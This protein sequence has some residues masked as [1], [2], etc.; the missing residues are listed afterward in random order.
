MENNV[1]E[2]V[3]SNL[4]WKLAERYG[5]QIVQFVVS[6]VLAR[7]LMPEIYGTIAL[8]MVFITILQVFV[9]SGFGS[10]LIQKKDSDDLDFSTVFY[11]NIIFCLILYVLIFFL[12]PVIASFYEN[13]DLTIIIRVLSISLIFSSL[14]NVQ[15]SYVSKN[16]MFKKF[17][18]A[19][20]IGTVCSAF[21]GIF[22]ALKGFGIWAIVSQNLTN[23][24]IDTLVL[25]ITV[26]WRPKKYFSFQRLK[27]LFSYGWKLLVSALL[28][29]SYNE[30][31]Q[32][33]IGKKYSK[34]DLAYYNKGEQFPK[35]IIT[36]INTS[37][38]S[39]LFSAMSSVQD[40]KDQVRMLTKKSIKLS[41]YVIAPMM[42]GLAVT[43]K[44][45]I[46]LVLTEKWLFATFFMQIFCITYM[47]Y[48]MHSSNL[49]AYKALGRSDLFLKLEI[50]KKLV[51]VSIL[52]VAMWFGV[53]AIAISLIIT[54]F[55]GIIINSWPNKKLLNY[56][57]FEQIK[58]IAPN[59]LLALVMGAICWL[60]GF[61]P[62]NYIVVLAIQIFVG[63]TVYI[64][65]SILTKNSEF[66]YLKNLLKRKRKNMKKIMLLGGSE[67]QIIA[68]TTAKNMGYYTILC[69]YLK[70]NPGQN[71]C[72]KFYLASTTD[73]EKI[74]EIAEK[75]KIDGIVAYASDPAAPTAAYVANKLNLPGN[76]FE[77]VEILC[78][79]DK[80]RE[81]LRQN[82]F[83]CPNS[84]GYDNLTEAENDIAKGVFSFPVLVKPVDS[85]GSK[86]VSKILNSD[87]VF[88]K[89]QNAMKFS[90]SKK[91]IIEE[92]VEKYGYQVAGDGLSVDGKLVFRYFGN[93][94]FDSKNA[95]PFV[96]VSASFPYNMPD[97]VHQK[98]HDE[99]QRL[100][101][102]LNM[103]NC[104]YN[105]DIRIDKDY[106]VYLMEIAP[107]D[108]GNYIPQIIKYATGVDLVRESIN[109]AMGNKIEIP[110]TD[111]KESYIA[112][113]A[114]HSYESGQLDEIIIDEK[115]KK[116]HIIEEHIIKNKGD[117]ITKFTGSNTTL[118]IILL[119]FNS[120]DEMIQ[121]IEND[122]WI[123]IQLL[124]NN[125]E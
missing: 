43:A 79:K 37:I 71:F 112:Y 124:E 3:F 76:P 40:K 115:F 91:I 53:K 122:D 34:E 12:A 107:R 111:I 14:K 28:D 35:L 52:L 26:K 114:V 106:N 99:I 80:F 69:D 13:A 55:M 23:T 16:M 75:E 95:N 96:P 33:I 93:D 60:L 92:Y 74:L 83:C 24:A 27:I 110:K 48:P 8:V 20:L 10:A 2:K 5:A 38:D 67:Q 97:E 62:L 68:I 1:K 123:S 32:L 100:L 70:D 120:L 78:N 44:S 64:A 82:D 108:G 77:S 90:I 113:Y 50:I 7:L 39:V 45:T 88:D 9:D 58:D 63:A 59:I 54:T 102:L 98:I 56:G 87:D 11:F 4:L 41:T 51:S 25:W 19:T 103:K 73:K 15:Q 85:S 18:F 105:F 84:K 65:G 42:I 46:R 104:T 118:G 49:N 125:N 121:N 31:R 72:D 61:L 94:H 29:T 6:I 30:L 47:F 117:Y 57:L 66:L 36:N 116:E 81:F 22:M 119:K 21:V 89:L 101:T 109:I 86:G 17:F